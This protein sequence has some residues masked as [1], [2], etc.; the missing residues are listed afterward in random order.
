MSYSIEEFNPP[1]SLV[2]LKKIE[3]EIDLITLKKHS[4]INS[5]FNGI[6]K[7]HET[8]K[9]E[10]QKLY[11][12]IWELVSDKRRFD[13]SFL[14]F[15]QAIHNADLGTVEIAKEFYRALHET[16]LNSSPLIKNFE[17]YEDIKK[18]NN[19]GIDKKPCYATYYDI[20]AK[21][22]SLTLDQFF[23]LTLRNVHIML[24]V[25]GDSAYKEL[26]VQA[27]LHGRKLKPKMD[28][29]D[30]PIAQDKEQEKQALEAHAELQKRF[31]QRQKAQ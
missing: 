13:Y 19:N 8:L 1:K 9:A 7:L 10:P 25:S 21:R 5:R 22:Y 29:E 11:F 16:I 14:K 31:E 26:E 28:T 6:D 15:N 2:S 27:A 30:I 20:L 3:F 24:K 17:R 23:D 18:I 12:I 4:I